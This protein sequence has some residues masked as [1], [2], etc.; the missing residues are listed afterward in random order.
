MSGR[1]IAAFACLAVAGCGSEQQLETGTAEA[2]REDVA[3]VRAAAEEGD[4]A[5][6]LSGLDALH[7]RIAQAESDGELDD[8]Q[9]VELRRAVRRAK[10]RVDQ[11]LAP[12]PPPA[13]VAEPPA[14]KP[15]PGK[16][17]PPGRGHGHG[18]DDDDEEGDD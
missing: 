17:P 16:G 9:A 1:W 2:L 10:R 11:E 8:R 6:A 4:R 5:G 7:A 15:K 12:E 18:D 14:K 3:E 13:P